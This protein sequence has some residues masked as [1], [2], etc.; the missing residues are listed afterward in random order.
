M[1]DEPKL[2][3]PWMVAVWPGM[4]HVAVSAGYYLMAKLGMHG[5]A[6]FS[7]RELF[8]IDHVDVK[9]GLIKTGR[10]P[11]SRL[12]AWNDPKKERDLVVFIGEAQPPS[13]RY[14]FSRRL[15]EY[16]QQLGVERIYTFAAMATQMHPEHAPRVFAAATNEELLAELRQE[17]VVILEIGQIS[18]LNGVL[19]G[20]AAEMGL[21]GA[22]LLGEMPHLFAQFPFPA[23][24][25]SVLKAFGK[26]AHIEIDLDELSQ[27]AE[28]MGK[29][30]GEILANV[31]EKIK[32]HGQTEQEE[33]EFS[34]PPEEEPRISATD[35]RRIERLFENAR[36]DRSK[37]YELKGELDRL[38]VFDLYEDRFLDLFKKPD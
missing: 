13:G 27:Q 31:E 22:C 21:H 30:L 14:L 19:L 3:K 2:I 38:G 18:G 35:E 12:F 34:A 24:S 28:E 9:A 1:P 5:L 26:M 11:R 10:L 4:G 32:E 36:E 7:P 15:V 37:A 23:A 25:L 29:R 16:A 8:D 6:E 17:E 33:P 20:V